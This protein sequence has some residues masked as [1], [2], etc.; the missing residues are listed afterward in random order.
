MQSQ[1][2]SALISLLVYAIVV[3]KANTKDILNGAQKLS[4]L[5]IL[6]FQL[7]FLHNC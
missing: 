2:I 3:H 1:Y 7:N 4:I 5:F 6:Y